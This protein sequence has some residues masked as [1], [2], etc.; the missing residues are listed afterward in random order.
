MKKRSLC[1][2]FKFEEEALLKIDA[3]YESG[4]KRN[5]SDNPLSKLFKGIGNQSGFRCYYKPAG[6][7]DGYRSGKCQGFVILFSICEEDKSPDYLDYETARM[8]EKL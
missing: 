2:V 4:K 1:I 3:I 6:I 8:A 5:V 7:C